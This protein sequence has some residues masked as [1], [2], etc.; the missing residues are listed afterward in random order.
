MTET[1]AILPESHP[2]WCTRDPQLCG[3][4]DSPIYS[5]HHESQ[6][7]TQRLRGAGEFGDPGAGDDLIV[8][9]QWVRIDSAPVDPPPS[10][11]DGI[12][13]II[14]NPDQDGCVRF[15]GAT[16]HIRKVAR[17]LIEHADQF[18]AWRE[19]EQARAAEGGGA[20]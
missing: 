17:A 1:T 15:H 2:E 18:D 8:S 6:P 11:T 16:G 5:A 19:A 14:E 7:R 20:S 13:V 3:P 10:H 12:E 4:S 9:V